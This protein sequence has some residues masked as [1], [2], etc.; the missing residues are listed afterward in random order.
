MY[1]ENTQPQLTFL[2]L[3]PW[4]GQ[5]SVNKTEESVSNVGIVNKQYFLKLTENTAKET[6]IPFLGT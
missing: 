5:C 2:A 4:V 6:K 3:L 1:A